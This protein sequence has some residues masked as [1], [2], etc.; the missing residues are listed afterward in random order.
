[1]PKHL[2][3]NSLAARNAQPELQH[4]CERLQ[5]HLYSGIYSGGLRLPADIP[6]SGPE[7]NKVL[8]DIALKDTI[9]SVNGGVI[10]A[11]PSW[12][13]EGDD[14][15]A[16]QTVRASTHLYGSER[17]EFVS[18]QRPERPTMSYAQLRLLFRA[19]SKVSTDG[20]LLSGSIIAEAEPHDYAFLRVFEDAP[21][22]SHDKLAAA[23]CKRIKPDSR[24]NKAWY[25][26]VPLAEL[27]GREFVT[28]VSNELGVFHVS[29]FLSN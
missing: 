28:P 11:M 22:N 21:A 20:S 23:G 6:S 27:T 29:C 7:K 5:Q 1:M 4:L 10:V 26:V 24:N 9:T 3:S 16:L 19:T 15:G 12:N 13:A 14:Y 2:S 8:C 18:F 17:F 25:E